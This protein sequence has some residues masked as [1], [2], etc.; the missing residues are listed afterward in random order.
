VEKIISIWICLGED[1]DRD[2]E[3]GRKIKIKKR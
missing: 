3:A 1:K 2:R